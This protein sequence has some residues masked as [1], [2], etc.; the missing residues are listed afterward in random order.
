MDEYSNLD[1]KRILIVDDEVDVLG[2]LEQLLDMCHID[3]A[4]TSREAKRLLNE[5]G[6]AYDVA[7]L[8]IMGV[9]G[10]DLLEITSQKGIPTLMLT[11]HA[12]NPDDFYKSIRGGA[13][14]YIPKEKMVDIASFVSDILQ[15]QQDGTQQQSRW[16]TKLRK[17]FDKIFGPRWY[18]KNQRFWKDYHWL[19]NL[20]QE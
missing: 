16:F 13:K 8:D 19:A 11:A 1:G 2:T 20:D 17:S 4:T 7:I 15:D 5:N 3:S 14:A 10:Y 18:R 9:D 6:D 12:L